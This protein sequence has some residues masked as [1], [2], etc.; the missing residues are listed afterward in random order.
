VRE[1]AP[2]GAVAE[3]VELGGMVSAHLR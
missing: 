1:N 3:R 2:A